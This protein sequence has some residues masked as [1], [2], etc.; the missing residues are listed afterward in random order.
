MTCHIAQLGLLP[1]VHIYIQCMYIYV[2]IFFFFFFYA[3]LAKR[4]KVQFRQGFAYFNNNVDS[5]TTCN[6]KNCYVIYIYVYIYYFLLCI[7]DMY[8]YNVF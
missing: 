4:W 2:Y 7:V 1:T 5:K 8:I 6:Y 3:A